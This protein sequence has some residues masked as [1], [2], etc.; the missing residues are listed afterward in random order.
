MGRASDG[1]AGGADCDRRWR[2]T[3]KTAC[4][5]LVS[6]AWAG[7]GA[8]FGPVVLFGVCWKRM[9]RNG[10][11]AGMIVGALT[12][13]VWKQYGWLG[14]YEIIPGFIFASI[15]IVVFTLM[16]REAISRS[17]AAL[18]RCRGGVP[19]QNKRGVNRLARP[20]RGGLFCYKR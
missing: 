19:D 15:A 17:A 12:V 9:N 1:A 2:L 20:E 13:L 14:L 6:Y 4:W 5:A 8:A 18:C 7:F 11:L 10:A 3:R 16:G